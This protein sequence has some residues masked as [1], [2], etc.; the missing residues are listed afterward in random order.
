MH[1]AHST[2]SQ[3]SFLPTVTNS[4]KNKKKLLH[5]F[6]FFL[7]WETDLKHK[8]LDRL[9]QKT[10]HGILLNFDIWIYTSGE[11]Q[12]ELL[13]T[14]IGRAKKFHKVKRSKME[15]QGKGKRRQERRVV[16]TKG[17]E[18]ATEERKESSRRGRK[19]QKEKLFLLFILSFYLLCHIYS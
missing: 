11:V 19:K 17:K 8:I 4:K 7:H 13:N 1:F 16:K 6:I 3:R 9:Y 14:L 10:L 5:P 2:D 12:K 18:R 15:E